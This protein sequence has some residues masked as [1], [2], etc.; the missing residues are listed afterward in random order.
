MH[1]CSECT[2]SWLNSLARTL[3]VQN[4]RDR[5]I[6]GEIWNTCRV[7]TIPTICLCVLPQSSFAITMGCRIQDSLRAK[8]FWLGREQK[9]SHL[10]GTRVLGR[11]HTEIDVL[12][13]SRTQQGGP[14]LAHAWRIQPRVRW[15]QGKEKG[16]VPSTSVH[17]GGDR[18]EYLCSSSLLGILVTFL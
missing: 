2:L 11:R 7:L 8:L 14:V 12:R 10:W 15:W 13:F 6:W 18:W 3:S 9:P 5:E 4:N 17:F 16:G 1:T